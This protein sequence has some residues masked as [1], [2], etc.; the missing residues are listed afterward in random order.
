MSLLVK[1][2]ILSESP[3]W[4]VSKS[5][6][7][8]FNNSRSL[9]E[10]CILEDNQNFEEK[11]LEQQKEEMFHSMTE[12]DNLTDNPIRISQFDPLFNFDEPELNSSEEMF[13]SFLQEN[14][15]D[16]QEL[17]YIYNNKEFRI[18]FSEHVLK[19][20][21][22]RSSDI[23]NKT[24]I[25]I[26]SL[27]VS[28]IFSDPENKDQIIT[29]KEV[30][31]GCPS[32]ESF[33]KPFGWTSETIINYN[34]DGDYYKTDITSIHMFITKEVNTKKHHRCIVNGHDRISG[35]IVGTDKEGQRPNPHSRLGLLKLST[36]VLLTFSDQQKLE[37]QVTYSINEPTQ[38]CNQ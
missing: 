18:I 2:M 24:S 21:L 31:N 16:N 22:V 28:I 13:S 8:D 32:K 14:T 4:R 3:E 36:K 23:D 9:I 37:Y 11:D 7:N 12:D 1:N 19:E 26:D 38:C 27:N 35:V 10:S 34:S 5:L 25:G 15:F 6:E 33:R 17:D 30:V 20:L 29:H